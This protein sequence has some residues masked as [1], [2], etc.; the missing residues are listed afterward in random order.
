MKEIGLQ[1]RKA[2]VLLH[3]TSLPGGYG[4]GNLGATARNFV[5]FVAECGIK[6]WQMLPV[7]PP[8]GGLSPYQ[9][10]SMHAGHPRFISLGPLVDKGWLSKEEYER[11]PRTEKGHKRGLD[12]AWQGFCRSQDNANKAMLEDFSRKHEYWLDD[13]ALF[14]ALHDEHPGKPWW[15]WP[16]AVRERE[17]QTIRALHDSLRPRTD[18]IRFQQMLFFE[19]WHALK[20]Y[21]NERGVE[22]FGDMPIFVAQDS[23]EVW[24]HQSSFF[25]APSGQ[26]TVVAGVPPDY[27][28]D[29]GQRWG[30]PLY[31]WDVL[32]RQ[33]FAF[34]K[35]RFKTQ[36]EL[37]DLIRI[38]HFRGFESYWEIPATDETAINGRWVKAGG[39][40]FFES[41]E[42]EFGRL[43]LIAE[44]LGIITDEVTGLRKRHGLPGMKILQFGFSGGPDNPYLPFHHE[45]NSVVY[46]GTHDNDTTLGWYL[47]LDEKTRQNLSGFIGPTTEPMP[48][49]MI[50]MALASRSAL[51]IL[52]MQDLLGLD[53][54]HRF[55]LP[56]T[57]EGNWIW[58][59][60]WPMVDPGL[61]AK[62][63]ALVQTYGRA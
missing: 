36:L 55:N 41:L 25:L 7:T 3:I 6:V 35:Q 60:D 52:P 50:R 31:R 42:D 49:P 44:D 46:T 59:F 39:D 32:E 21:A 12:L 2:G 4:S 10:S 47:E 61:A 57:S 11:L 16:E 24:S 43:P 38:D 28:S 19:Q 30:N 1:G 8:Q 63:L 23:A 20:Q 54:A 14:E 58:R 53:G 13:F 51:A 15:E 56:G 5:N 37:F 40:A 33:G 29:T 9:S 48:W 22:L 26:P 27:F 17:P 45:R 62:M 18:R 34:W